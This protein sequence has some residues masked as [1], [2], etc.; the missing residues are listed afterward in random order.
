MEK[1]TGKVI[2]RVSEETYGED[3]RKGE[4]RDI[5]RSDRKG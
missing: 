1:H 3:D 4:C 2:G 5:W